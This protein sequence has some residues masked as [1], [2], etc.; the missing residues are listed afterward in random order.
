MLPLAVLP[1]HLPVGGQPCHSGTRGGVASQSVRHASFDETSLRYLSEEGTLVRIRKM[2]HLVQALLRWRSQRVAWRATASPKQTALDQAV[3][4]SLELL[5]SK[6][7]NDLVLR[8]THA[9]ERPPAEESSSSVSSVLGQANRALWLSQAPGAPLTDPEQGAASLHYEGAKLGPWKAPWEQRLAPAP[10]EAVFDDP[11]EP[12]PELRT[13]GPHWMPATPTLCSTSV[14]SELGL[15]SGSVTPV[16]LAQ[17]ASGPATPGPA[18]PAPASNGHLAAAAAAAAAGSGAG[19][20]A[21]ALPRCAL[22]PVWFPGDFALVQS[23]LLGDRGVIPSGIVQQARARF[24]PELAGGPPVCSK[25][26]WP[27]TPAC[28]QYPCAEGHAL[29]IP[30]PPQTPTAR[31]CAMTGG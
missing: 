3:R 24:E 4:P 13:Q 12:P 26:R 7:H 28:S 29:C 11:F 18:P 5:A 2:K 9:A 14:P 10:L 17:M 20:P 19:S 31:H 30:P 1:R 25:P 6:R 21:A 23:C 16:S 27:C 15:P 22:L 8:L